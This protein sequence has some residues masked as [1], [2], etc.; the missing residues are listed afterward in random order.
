MTKNSFEKK[1]ELY[2][3]QI[4]TKILNELSKR[5]P[6][7]LYSPLIY[8]LSSGGKRLRAIL[9]LF[10]AKSVNENLKILPI[11]Q[12][13]A[14]ELLHNFTLIHDDI[15]D[16]SDT[17]HN[18]QTV[19]KKYDLSTAI[20][21]GDALLAIAYEFLDKNLKYNS[22]KIYEEFTKA[23]RIVC[24]GQAL[25][26]EFETKNKVSLK[27]Y[28]EMI[29][30]KTAALIKAA[31]K[32]GALSASDQIN[33]K[34]ID[35]FGLFGEY[36]GIAFQIQDDLLDII[37]DYKLFGK[38]KALDLLEGKKTYLL[39]KALDLA[40]GS[41]LEKLNKLIENKGIKQTELNEYI[42]I[43]K[44]TGV[45]ELAQN[46]ILNYHKKANNVLLKLSNK[47][48]VHNL[49]NVLEFVINRQY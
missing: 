5:K 4:N 32:I 17:R 10:A 21:S 24:E 2:K 35:Q 47:Y 45:I 15:M 12:A 31:M 33:K 9:V 19:H 40:K 44:R 14:I 36:L 39:L 38:T 42:E 43:Y 26:K 16:N 1:L 13:I 29:S 34:D 6:K 23:L 30:M 37:G 27:E 7:S 25:D 28:F 11:N 3:T 41:D 18:K 22:I 8:F 48:D 20:L 49:K 46:E